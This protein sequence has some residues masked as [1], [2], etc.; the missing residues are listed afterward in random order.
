M[1]SARAKTLSDARALGRDRNCHRAALGQGLQPRQLLGVC[2]LKRA[3]P[4]GTSVAAD[5]PQD[6]R[7]LTLKAL[8]SRLRF[9]PKIRRLRD[10][11]RRTMA[12]GA[13]SSAA[14][15]VAPALEL[16]AGPG[17]GLGVRKTPDWPARCAQ[18]MRQGE[19][20]R[21]L[22]VCAI[23]EHERRPGIGQG[24]PR[25]SSGIKTTTVVVHHHAVAHHE[26]PSPSA[27]Q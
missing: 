18:L 22:G 10:T 14:T 13:S 20:L 15:L 2:A 5:A 24:E 16:V 11:P 6:H 4:S 3:H 9:G 8:A 19:H 27:W 25:N 21:G 7:V 1:T 23:D 26:T 17:G 12:S